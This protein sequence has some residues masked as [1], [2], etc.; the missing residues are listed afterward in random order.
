[1]IFFINN[2]EK[3]Q[4]PLGARRWSWIK[5][6]HIVIHFE[7][8]EK[9]EKERDS[10]LSSACGERVLFFLPQAFLF[11]LIPLFKLTFFIKNTDRHHYPSLARCVAIF[12]IF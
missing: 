12:F 10:P 8:I 5:K 6:A 2:Q 3:A 9:Q 7:I 1:M 4:A 11:G